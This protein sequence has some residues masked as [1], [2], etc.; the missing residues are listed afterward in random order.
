MNQKLQ[1]ISDKVYTRSEFRP[2]KIK[3]VNDWMDYVEERVNAYKES[4]NG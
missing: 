2:L 3:M 1:D 4:L